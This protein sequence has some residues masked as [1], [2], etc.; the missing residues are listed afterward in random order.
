MKK[1]SRII[2]GILILA[3][4]VILFGNAAKLW[5]VSI[6]FDGWWAALVMLL[7]LFSICTDKPNIVNVYFLLFG[8]VMLF[9]E[10][11]IFIAKDTSPWLIALALLIIVAGLS[12]IIRTAFGT[13]RKSGA[14]VR[15]ISANGNVSVS[16]CEETV[17]FGSNCFE[18]GDYSVAFGSLTIDLRMAKIAENAHL[19]VKAS[20]GELKVLLPENADAE[21]DGNAF[22][23]KVVSPARGGEIPIKI[24][25]SAIF[26]QVS[27]IK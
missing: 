20:F 9:K 8:G 3:L 17:G 23:G 2:W 4:G 22:L 14:A 27:I 13:K 6:F 21:V 16:F 5:D 25:A 15:A 24:T 10:Q 11:G 19:S 1:A 26:G 18:T 7:A 12:I